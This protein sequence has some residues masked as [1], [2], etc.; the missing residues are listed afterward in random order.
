I[1]SG[2]SNAAQTCS[3]GALMMT[4]ALCFIGLTPRYGMSLISPYRLTKAIAG[5]LEL[6]HS[7]ST[8]MV[9]RACP[10]KA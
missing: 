5:S 2:L 9:T 7:R 3:R 4:S 1:F 6:G 10:V 8:L